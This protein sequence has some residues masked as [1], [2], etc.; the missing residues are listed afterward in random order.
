MIDGQKIIA[1]LLVGGAG[2][3][4][5]PV[6]TEAHP[7][8]FLKLF[9]DRSLFQNTL[10]RLSA[11]A[12][13]EIVIVTGAAQVLTVREQIAELGVSAPYLLLEPCRRDS[14]AAISAG[15]AWI[16]QEI[17]S[18]AIIAV[19]P[20]D[21]YI[22]DA[23][24]FAVA[25]RRGA[26]LAAQDW[27]VTFGIEPR[28]P[29]TEYGYIQNGGRLAGAADGTAFTVAK[30]HEKPMREVAEAYLRA[31]NYYWNSGIFVFGADFFA[32]QAAHHM[33]DI[34]EPAVAAVAEGKRQNGALAADAEAFQ[35]ARQS[36]IDYALLE[37]CERVAVVPVD[38]EWHDIGSW[39]SVYQAFT[40]E[41]DQN[42]ILG[43]VVLDDASGALVIADQVKVVVCGLHDVV[44]I[45]SRHGTLV[46]P[47]SKAA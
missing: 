30:F 40:R 15:V 20:A 45:A 36:A 31:G 41:Q 12:V 46:A 42:L 43:D 11:T 19:L 27:L 22:P 34:W 5:W 24:Q 4:L 25:L 7:K 2:T 16:R 26:K 47:R 21:H 35:R 6:S 10:E 14:A 32:Q 38:F 17:A 39:G 3:R 13:D 29:T 9:G 1:L 44:V 18:K 23:G 8:Q 37:K 28:H 33:P